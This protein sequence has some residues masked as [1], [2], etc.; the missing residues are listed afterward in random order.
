MIRIKNKSDLDQYQNPPLSAD[1][2]QKNDLNSNNSYVGFNNSKNFSIYNQNTN[3][4]N[5]IRKDVSLPDQL[6]S[7]EDN[8]SS[9]FKERLN[10]IDMK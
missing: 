4:N 9:N 1:R 10:Q 7:N 8:S 5:S 6:K 2:S 3:S